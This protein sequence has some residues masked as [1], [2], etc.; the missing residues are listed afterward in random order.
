[1]YTDPDTVDTCVERRGSTE[2]GHGG[3]RVTEY[4]LMHSVVLT[5]R[6]A[7]EPDVACRGEGERVGGGP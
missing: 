5:R 4:A 3:E 2:H 1:M 7:V 6:A